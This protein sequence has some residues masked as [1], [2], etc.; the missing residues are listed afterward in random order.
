MGNSIPLVVL[1]LFFVVFFLYQVR[2]WKDLEPM[3]RKAI[4]VGIGT[5]LSAAVIAIIDPPWAGRWYISRVNHRFCCILG[6]V[7]RGM[8]TRKYL[9]YLRPGNRDVGC[10]Q[11]RRRT[12]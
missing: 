4:Y 11:Q 1:A 5:A 3:S 7:L 9:E 6:V 8:K 2:K 12:Q 10:P